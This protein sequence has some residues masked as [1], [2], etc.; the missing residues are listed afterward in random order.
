MSNVLV[1]RLTGLELF[2]RRSNSGHRGDICMFKMP[3]RGKNS[4]AVICYN[5]KCSRVAIQH[6]QQNHGGG[7]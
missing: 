2:C 7:L 5:V 1:P 6:N 4:T 3:P